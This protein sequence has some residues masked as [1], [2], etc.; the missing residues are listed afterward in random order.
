MADKT[1]IKFQTCHQIALKQQHVLQYLPY[2][3]GVD[4]EV[5]NLG[6]VVNKPGYRYK[7]SYIYPVAFTSTKA[8]KTLVFEQEIMEGPN[9]APIFRV[10][11]RGTNLQVCSLRAHGIGMVAHK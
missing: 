8:W 3:L 7:K 4:V 9:D 1:D 10:S 5:T 6:H 11:V 2:A